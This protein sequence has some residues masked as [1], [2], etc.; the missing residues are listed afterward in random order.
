MIHL[1]CCLEY[2]LLL[3]LTLSRLHTADI[4]QRLLRVVHG[5]LSVI[6]MRDRFFLGLVP[7]DVLSVARPACGVQV[8]RQL[9]CPC[10]DIAYR[11]LPHRRLSKQIGCSCDTI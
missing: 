4:G 6:G 2:S 5:R 1:D 7:L 11:F 3:D 9:G 8:L 10:V